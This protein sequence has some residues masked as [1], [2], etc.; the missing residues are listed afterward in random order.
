[1]FQSGTGRIL[2]TQTIVTLVATVLAALFGVVAAYSAFLGGLACVILNAYSIWRVF[3][4]KKSLSPADPQIFGI[5]LR[6]EFMKFVVA[7]ITFALFFYTISEINP[8]AM[9]SVFAIA[10]FAGLVEAGLRIQTNPEKST[11]VSR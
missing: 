10:T 9:F 4:R 3:G 8:I 5:M 6:A 2:V 7:C 11:L 1:M